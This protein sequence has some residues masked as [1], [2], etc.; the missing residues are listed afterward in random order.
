M[1]R[2]RYGFNE[3]KIK[4]FIDEGRGLGTGKS[5]K[6]W[7][8]VAD[9]P[10]LGRS[11]RIYITKTE[12]FHHLL[13]DNEYYAFLL[14]WWDDTVTD[15]R[16][17][18][19]ILDRRETIGIAALL[20]IPYPVD[21]RSGAP[22]IITTDLL[23]NKSKKNKTET[24]AYAIKPEKDLS[25]HRTIEKLEIE[26]RYWE[27]QN[28]Q[29]KLLIDCQLRTQFTKNLAWVVDSSIETTTFDINKRD[30]T[31]LGELKKRQGQH[32]KTPICDLCKIIDETLSSPYG[33]ALASVRRLIAKKVLVVDLNCNS[34]QKLPFSYY[35]IPEK[36][37]SYEY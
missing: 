32:A 29:W 13:S 28:I 3:K 20:R 15:I 2:V 22:Y 4:R 35:F 24:I 33:T 8:T 21:V 18:F 11:H 27:R 37:D 9:V 30:I 17:Q 26:R 36:V 5:Y 25:N 12:R 19:P 31:V 6:P 23:V 7:L 1:A 34:I 16:E 14:Q 10:S